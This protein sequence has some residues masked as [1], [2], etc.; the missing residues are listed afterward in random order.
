MILARVLL[1]GCLLAAAA[2][3]ALAD[4]RSR[5]LSPEERRAKIASHAV[6]TLS[7]AIRALK[8]AHREL[9][10]ASLCEHEGR[11]VYMLT[12]L[13]RD[14]KV[15]RATVDAGNGSVIVGR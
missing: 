14:G 8:V 11:L 9:I 10:R 7:K 5:C 15:A 12:V 1:T 6:I 2:A 4:G 13:G 3:P